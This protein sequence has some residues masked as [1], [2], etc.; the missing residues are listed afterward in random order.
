[1]TLDGC[2]VRLGF[3]YGSVSYEYPAS[4]RG[5][6]NTDSNRIQAGLDVEFSQADR[7]ELAA[8]ESI[9]WSTTVRRCG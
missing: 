7:P 5:P 8:V 3:G 1:M 6:G 2:L 4:D 9:R